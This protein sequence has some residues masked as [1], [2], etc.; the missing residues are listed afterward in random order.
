M[1]HPNCRRWACGM[2]VPLVLGAVV[3][4]ILKVDA[5]GEAYR[6]PSTMWLIVGVGVGIFIGGIWWTEA[7]PFRHAVAP[8]VTCLVVGSFLTLM[9]VD[10]TD[11]SGQEG[12]GEPRPLHLDGSRRRGER[13]HRWNPS[14]CTPACNTRD[15]N[16]A[17]GADVLL[18]GNVPR[19]RRRSARSVSM[20]RLSSRPA[21]IV[22]R[23]AANALNPPI[24][25]WH[26]G[27]A[28]AR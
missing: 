6:T 20:E 23:R 24:A 7:L 16:D 22:A 14:G 1:V 11:T 25:A 5:A 8:C 12:F 26:D 10:G 3:A 21:A 28:L 9:V 15:Q 4:G 19:H 27:M 2:L 17:C 18:R 13:S